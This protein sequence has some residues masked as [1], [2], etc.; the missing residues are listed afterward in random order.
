MVLDKLGVLKVYEEGLN[1]Y[2]RSK[3]KNMFKDS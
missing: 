1:N 2:K 3:G